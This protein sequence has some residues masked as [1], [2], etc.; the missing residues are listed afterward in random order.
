MSSL[1]PLDVI[2]KSGIGRCLLALVVLGHWFGVNKCRYGFFKRIFYESDIVSLNWF[3]HTD[4]LE[5]V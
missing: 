2:H 5:N 3:F 4:T 1:E